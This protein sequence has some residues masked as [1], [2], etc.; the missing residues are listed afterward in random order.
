MHR[1]E[2]VVEALPAT[3]LPLSCRTCD[4]IVNAYVRVGGVVA[5]VEALKVD[6]IFQYS[7][8]IFIFFL[9]FHGKHSLVYYPAFVHFRLLFVPVAIGTMGTDHF[10][11]SETF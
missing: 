1:L 10:D 6:T 9:I 5:A 3:C 11:I 2:T 7:M 8:S 4:E